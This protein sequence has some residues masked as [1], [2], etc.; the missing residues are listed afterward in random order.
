MAKKLTQG[1]KN[2]VYILTELVSGS[3]KVIKKYFKIIYDA[4]SIS[5]TTSDVYDEIQFLSIYVNFLVD[6]V[7]ITP[8]KVKQATKIEDNEIVLYLCSTYTWVLKTIIKQCE[9][10]LKLAKKET[11]NNEC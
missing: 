7:D 11:N 1:E 9:E 8:E 6:N 2:L 10:K 4:D 5:V 3:N